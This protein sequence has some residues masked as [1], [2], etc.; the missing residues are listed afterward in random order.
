M[1][2]NEHINYTWCQRK[3]D[4]YWDSDILEQETLKINNIDQVVVKTQ[5]RYQAYNL[6][7]PDVR[8]FYI[9]PIIGVKLE[10]QIEYKIK[11]HYK[12]KIQKSWARYD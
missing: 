9:R 11:E 12:S 7:R 2:A 10:G 3:S 5:W 8:Y 6:F 4:E 1:N